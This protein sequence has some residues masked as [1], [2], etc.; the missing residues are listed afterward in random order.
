ML[1]EFTTALVATLAIVPSASAMNEHELTKVLSELAAAAGDAEETYMAYL[2]GDSHKMHKVRE[3]VVRSSEE[4]AVAATADNVKEKP[5][6]LRVLWSSLWVS[7]RVGPRTWIGYSPE[8][9]TSVRSILLRQRRCVKSYHTW[10][11]VFATHP[12]AR[13]TLL[14]YQSSHWG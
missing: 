10:C 3:L 8:S 6:F 13:T 2:G 5:F 14:R 11:M 1:L 4:I 7:S 9:Q 12:E